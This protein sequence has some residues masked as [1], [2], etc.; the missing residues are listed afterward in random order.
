MHGKLAPEQAQSLLQQ[1]AASPGSVELMVH[2]LA[3]HA[4]AVKPSDHQREFGKLLDQRGQKAGSD[5]RDAV[6]KNLPLIQA[7][8]KQTGLHGPGTAYYQFQAGALG[9]A[10]EGTT[11]VNAAGT[12]TVSTEGELRRT[13]RVPSVRFLAGVEPRGHQENAKYTDVDLDLKCGSA[14]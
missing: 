10:R 6:E 4:P 5:L 9:A 13:P 2:S 3:G 1:I 11:N 8:V 14:N 7:S 12:Q